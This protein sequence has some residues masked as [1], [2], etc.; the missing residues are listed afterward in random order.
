MGDDDHPI[1]IGAGYEET[2]AKALLAAEDSLEEVE[3]LIS[4]TKDDSAYSIDQ[5]ISA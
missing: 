5:N 3:R 4:S 2:R 1:E